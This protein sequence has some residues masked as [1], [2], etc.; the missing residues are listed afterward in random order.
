M[1]QA[2]E[3]P[4]FVGFERCVVWRGG[5]EF[6][7]TGVKSRSESAS[8][9][10]VAAS[11]K[12]SHREPVD[13]N[14]LGGSAEKAFRP[15]ILILLTSFDFVLSCF[16]LRAFWVTEFLRGLGLCIGG[17]V[18]DLPGGELAI[19]DGR[20]SRGLGEWK[21]GKGSRGK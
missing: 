14:R 16:G 10:D 7:L 12:S 2:I 15:S 4:R 9:A 13:E 8:L 6:S 17:R 20:S 3:G 5:K 19:I 1:R 21:G 18:V 11:I